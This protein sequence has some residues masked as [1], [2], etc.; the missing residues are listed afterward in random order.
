MGSKINPVVNVVSIC[1]VILAPFY[2]KVRGFYDNWKVFD[3]E[4]L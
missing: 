4:T 1:Y 2:G 3:L